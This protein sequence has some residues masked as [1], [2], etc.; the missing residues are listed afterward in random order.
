MHLS[1][2]AILHTHLRTH[3]PFGSISVENFLNIG[4][5]MGNGRFLTKS[6][7]KLALTCPTKLYYTGKP[8]QFADNTT[9]DAFMAALADG[10]FQVGELAKLMHPGGIE[11][12]ATGNADALAQ[13]AE[14][15]RAHTVTLFE[16]AIAHGPYLVRVDILR[17]V[18]DVVDLI[19]VKAKS[20]AS[21]DVHAFRAGRGQLDA[22]MLP[23]LQ[24]V[25]FQ[26]HV[27]SLAQPQW[28][29]CTHLMLADTKRRCSV[30]RLNQRFKI[31]RSPG[32]RQH[33]TVA[34]STDLASLGTPVLSTVCVDEY[35]NEILAGTLP[36]PEGNKPFSQAVE[37]WARHYITDTKMPPVIGARCGHCE[38]RSASDAS[39]QSGFHVCWQE[40]QGLSRDQVE[41]GTV[42]DLW[43]FA[44]KQDLIDRGVL[45]LANV[46]QA[47]LNLRGESAGLSNSQR[48][49]MQVS[50]QWP[51]GGDFYL[52]RTYL[53]D[54]MRTWRYPLHFIDFETARVALPFFAGQR[55][56]TNVAFQ[57]SHHV[58]DERG[59]VAHAH[60]FLSLEPGVCPNIPFVRALKAALAGDSGTVFMWSPHENTTLLD[61]LREIEEMA[62]PV[63]DAPELA[64]FIRSLTVQKQQGGVVR[65]GE[66]AMVDLCALARKAY[67]HPLTKGSCS[68]KKVLPA[69]MASSAFLRERYSQPVYGAEGGIPSL[70]FRDWAWWQA[71]G[72]GA[73]SPYALL[74]PVF[75]DLSPALLEAKGA[76]DN[77][78]LADGGSATTA[79]A[80]MQFEDAPPWQ[81]EAVEEALL[82]YCELDTLA[83]VMVL[84]GWKN[85]R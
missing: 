83:M 4:A 10:G 47:D 65:I 58:M 1:S 31:S 82:R 20:F 84:E 28:R 36:T 30:S 64:A 34:P 5:H 15:L 67:F 22:G 9:D 3:K 80:R 51:G 50:G 74:P 53:R 40:A 14:L 54:A 66:R 69:V 59:R 57:F 26:K 21:D 55:P 38:F 72:D 63:P 46:T 11:V 27:V 25:A 35:T 73:R 62:P 79:W 44:R 76:D 78:S 56:Y 45:K 7:F 13:T 85:A 61:L 19:E 43:S 52:D 68:I 77:H 60:Q 23:Y 17:K 8:D 75:D 12:M 2:A 81:R 29:V 48:Q 42:L 37:E 33:V 41:Q 16:A 32:G 70:N 49:W 39:P 71:E 6:R 24:D 18:G